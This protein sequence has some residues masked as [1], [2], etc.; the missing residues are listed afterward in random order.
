[1]A[2]ALESKYKELGG[3]IH[4]NRK[5]TTILRDKGKA[6]GIRL[7]DMK[8]YLAGRII[9]AADGHTTLYNMLE[10]KYLDEK[11][12]TPYEK[13]PMFPSLIFISLGVNRRFDDIPKTVSGITFK[14]KESAVVGD[15]S[16][17]WLPVHIFNQD[18]TLA[19]DGKTALTIMLESD[20]GYWL[21]LAENR[22][23]YDR[24]KEEIAS[25]IIELLEQRF[26]GITPLVEVKDVATPLTFERYTGNWKGC[27][28]GWLI[29]PENSYTLMK[30]MPQTLPGLGSF[31]MCGQWV[32]PGGGLPTALMSAKRLMKKICKED[33]VK[34]RSQSR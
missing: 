33:G 17:D 7:D 16:R 15:K 2:L 5:V 34:F 11:S 13:W 21:S 28:E 1:M 8:E 19:P 31:Y 12:R 29:T 20:Y 6:V 27:F 25:T 26:P 10:G 24:K 4:Y 9:S 30:P 14:L 23:E 22:K 32:E 18:S 3:I